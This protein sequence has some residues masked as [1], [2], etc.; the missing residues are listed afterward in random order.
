MDRL[1]AATISSVVVDNG[2]VD[3]E[4]ERLSAKPLH[5]NAAELN[6]LLGLPRVWNVPLLWAYSEFSTC[7]GS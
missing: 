1:R 7:S 5:T 4:E 6:G 2:E 3:G